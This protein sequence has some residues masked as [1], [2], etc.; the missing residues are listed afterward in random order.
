MLE[1]Q[2]QNVGRAML[3]LK[4]LGKN[5]SLLFPDSGNCQ[6]SLSFQTP[7]SHELFPCVSSMPSN[8][9]LLIDTSYGI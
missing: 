9:T 6:Q 8:L 2:N 7:S 5:P 3:P 1:V 4:A